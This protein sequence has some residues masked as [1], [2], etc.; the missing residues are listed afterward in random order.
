MFVPSLRIWRLGIKSLAMHPLRSLLTVLGVFIGTAS[1]IWLLAVGE[2]ISLKA[3]EQ[4]EQLGANNIIVRTVKRSTS[5]PIRTSHFVINGG[6]A[7]LSWRRY[8][9]S[10]TD[11]RFAAT[12][13]GRTR[14]IN[15]LFSTHTLGAESCSITFSR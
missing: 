8:H 10:I 14:K 6:K 7:S 3:Q 15:L 4:I 5:T 13:P 12:A 1:V 2:G 9:S 11:A